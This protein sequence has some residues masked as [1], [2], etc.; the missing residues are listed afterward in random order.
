[1]SVISSSSPTTGRQCQGNGSLKISVTALLILICIGITYYAHFIQGLDVVFTHFFYVPLVTAA[2]WWGRRA[3]W[4]ALFLGGWL[5]TFHYLSGLSIPYPSDLL[6]FGMFVMVSLTAGSFREQAWRSEKAA[7]LAYAEASELAYAELEQIFNTAGS[8]MRVLDKDFNVLRI[9]E[10][11]S[12]LAGISKDEAVSKKCY[13]VFAGPSCHTPGCTLSRILSGQ[14]RVEYEVEKE[15]NDGIRIPCILTATPFRGPGGKLIGIVENFKDITARKQTEVELRKHREH[16]EELVE[17]RTKK[18]EKLTE[19]LQL[20][21][22]ERRRAE[23]GLR[24]SSLYARSLIE[25]GLD[26]LVIIGPDGKIT[27]VNKGTELV[28]GVSRDRLIGSDFFNYFTEPEKA[29]DGYKEVFLNGF[30]KDYPLAMRHVSGKVTDVSYNATLYKNEAGEIQGIFAAARDITERKRAEEEINKLNEDLKHH[31]S[32]L[33]AANK[34]LEAFSYS[35]SHDLR[36][37]LRAINGFSHVLMEDYADKLDDE[38]KRLLDIISSN[39]QKMGQL[40]DDLLAFSHIGRQEIGHSDIDMEKLV[41]TVF[42]EFEPDISE[43]K[44][45]FT[46]KTLPHTRGDRSMIKQV[47]VNLLSNAVKFT[48]PRETAVIEVGGKSEGNENIY[49]VKDNGVGFDMKYVD[50]LFGVFQRLH[51]SSEFE[52]TGAGLAIVQRIIHRHGGRV[53]G[54]GKVDGNATVYF[55]LPAVMR[56]EG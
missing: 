7:E 6:R 5:L 11:F 26:P 31:A 19:E 50:K 42:E 27:D 22:A 41:K 12:R 10:T 13:E 23:E 18:L 49:Y 37:P 36:A 21:I 40:I 48:K 30:I 46:I 25:A 43:R 39:T 32:Q 17:E 15:R 35:V 8:G 1:M 55:T 2:F 51:S 47:F 52:G 16:L 3:V 34:E 44:V 20:E 56:A 53:W 4:A 33:E 24:A 45:Q 9:N 14:E 29:K 38:G 28:T 54:E